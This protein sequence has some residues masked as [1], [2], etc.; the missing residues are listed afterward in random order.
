MAMIRRGT[1]QTLRFSA[2]VVIEWRFI[3]RISGIMGP[4][5]AFREIPRGI[6]VARRGEVRWDWKEPQ[7]SEKNGRQRAPMPIGG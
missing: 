7:R 4:S 5:A 3:A 2:R 1:A 6:T